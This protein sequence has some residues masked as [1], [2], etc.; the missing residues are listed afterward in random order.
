MNWPPVKIRTDCT[1][2]YLDPDVLYIYLDK[3]CTVH[4]F[5]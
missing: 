5:R 1:Y 2:I 4:I 3:G